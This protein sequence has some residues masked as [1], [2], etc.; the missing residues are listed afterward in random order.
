MTRKLLVVDEEGTLATNLKTAFVQNFALTTC[1]SLDDVGQQRFPL[2]IISAAGDRSSTICASAMERGVAN[3][4]VIV[5]AEPSLD[6]AISAIRAGACDFISNGNDA[7]AIVSRVSEIWATVELSADMERIRAEP[8]TH[9]ELPEIIG[10]SDVIQRLRERLKRVASSDVS[11]LITGE[12]GTGKD[13]VAHTIHRYGRRPNG[14]YVAVNCNAL[15]HQ[16]IESEF[17][18]YVKGAFTGANE[19]HAGFLVEATSGT[20]YLDEISEIPFELQSKLLRAIQ[21]KR[22]RPL[23]QGTEVPYDAR[24]I[25]SSSVDLEKEVATGRFR[26]DL[27]FRL[28][29][30]RVHLPP[31]RERARDVLLLA[32]HFIRSASSESKPVVGFTPAVARALLAYKW[33]GNVRELQHCIVSAVNVAHHDQITTHDLPPSLRESMTSL[34]EDTIEL[35]PLHERERLHILEILQSV[36]GNKSLAARHLGLDRKTL[37][38]KL[39]AYEKSVDS[40]GADEPS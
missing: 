23:G 16:L 32:Q 27:F 34:R 36:G 21:E 1:K 26:K 2:A 31:L 10:E 25:A 11:V 6:E 13:V 18:G 3:R 24:L 37:A 39:R 35:M 33:P 7:N 15:S 20:I 12:S 14:P 19:D 40:D 28:N 38:R 5:G 4:V 17:F 29:V 30:V 22:V 8:V 9:S